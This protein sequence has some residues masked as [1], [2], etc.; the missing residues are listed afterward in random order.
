MRS[1]LEMDQAYS[2]N[3]QKKVSQR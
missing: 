3:S 1:G 2:S